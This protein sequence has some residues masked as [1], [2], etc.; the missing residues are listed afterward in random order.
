MQTIRAT[1][2]TL[3]M[4]VLLGCT[5]A[6]P[7]TSPSPTLA[8]TPTEPATPSPQ[9]AT[10]QPATAQP[11][12]PTAQ[13]ATPTVE[14]TAAATAASA[15]VSIFDFGF[16]PEVLEISTGTQVNWRND[17]PSP[18]TV[19]FDDGPDSG[20]LEAGETF[21]F[22]FDTAGTFDYICTIHPSMTATISVND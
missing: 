18:H 5:G 22:T 3:L 21:E 11:A 10:P 4:V 8:P 2:F 12:T 7:A 20:T 16:N 6:A 15:S 17:G 19:T 14:P 13:P 1:S 9:P